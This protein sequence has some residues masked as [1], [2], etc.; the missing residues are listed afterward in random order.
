MLGEVPST[1]WDLAHSHMQM[2]DIYSNIRV[3]DP[4][5]DKNKYTLFL[6]DSDAESKYILELESSS[7]SKNY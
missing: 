3:D 1:S 4:L 2:W 7:E 5:R 6:H